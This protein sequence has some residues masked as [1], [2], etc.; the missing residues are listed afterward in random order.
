MCVCVARACEGGSACRE[1]RAERAGDFA[2]PVAT[3]LNASR[4][5]TRRIS[6]NDNRTA[7]RNQAAQKGCF[8]SDGYMD[9]EMVAM[10]NAPGSYWL[11]PA[12]V[13]RIVREAPPVLL[14]FRSYYRKR[15]TA[16]I[17]E[18]TLRF[19][20]ANARAVRLNFTP[21]P[22]N[23]RDRTLV[24]TPLPPA[25]AYYRYLPDAEYKLI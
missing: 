25:T 1:I 19:A 2:T 8:A 24:S 6:R 14:Y 16:R 13:G 11:T 12:S 20:C 7:C 18:A 5:A 10:G 9:S 23:Q 4:E 22:N 3:P 15:Q 17:D 21:P